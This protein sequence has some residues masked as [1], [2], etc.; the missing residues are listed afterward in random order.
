MT[1]IVAGSVA[2]GIVL[3]VVIVLVAVHIAKKRGS[4]SSRYTPASVH[5]DP[6]IKPAAR[7]TIDG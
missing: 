2:G 4:S 5:E 7:Q 6:P 1:G 3:I